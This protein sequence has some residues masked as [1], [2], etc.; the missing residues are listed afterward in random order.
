LLEKLIKRDDYRTNLPP[1][2]IFRVSRDKFKEYRIAWREIGIHAVATH[3]PVIT[4]INLCGVER[5]GVIVPIQKVY[6]IVENDILKAFKLLIYINSD[7]A[8]SLVKLWAWSARGGYYEHTSYNMGLLPIPRALVE[9]NLWRHIDKLVRDRINA[10]NVDLNRLAKS[11]SFTEE[12]EK[13]LAEALGITWEEYKAIVEYGKWLNEA[14]P[15]QYSVE[16]LK[17]IE[18]EE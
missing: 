3:L 13:E 16:E 2:V 11:I 18:E 9:G 6:F 17:E 12:M 8:R 4:K 14:I 10:D 5:Q 7:I 1:W 15:L